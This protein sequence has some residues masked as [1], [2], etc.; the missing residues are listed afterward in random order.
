M[1][2]ASVELITN[3]AVTGAAVQWPGGR[4]FFAVDGTFGGASAG[5]E[6][7]TRSGV[8]VPYKVM[9][10]AGVRTAV[11]AITAADGFLF[12]LPP[13]PIR[14]TLT[15]GAPSAMYAG[16]SRIPY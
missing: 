3:G 5:L 10:G 8:W 12:E 11:P 9:D 13:C 1:Q 2:T 4:G 14:A 16:A 7:Q 15:G 6:W